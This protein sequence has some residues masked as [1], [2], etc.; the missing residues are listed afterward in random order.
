MYSPV[1]LQIQH[2]PGNP[3][4]YPRQVFK[5]SNLNNQSADRPFPGPCICANIGDIIDVLILN[6]LDTETLSIHFHGLNMEGNPWMD[7]VPGITECGIP[8]GGNFTYKFQ[9]TQTGKYKYYF[10]TLII[11]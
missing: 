4:G 5:V 8:P 10:F 7:G 3:D 1:S 9:L 6:S 2:V 11:V